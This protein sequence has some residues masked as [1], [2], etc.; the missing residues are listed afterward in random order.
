MGVVFVEFFSRCYFAFEGK[1]TES[2]GWCLLNCWVENK[3]ELRGFSGKKAGE[4]ALI[5]G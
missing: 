2:L 1:I 4:L 5:T 3:G